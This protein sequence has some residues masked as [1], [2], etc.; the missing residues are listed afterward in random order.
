[1]TVRRRVK[2]LFE[3]ATLNGG[4]HSFLAVAPFLLSEFDVSALL[5]E[6]GPL[7]PR[8]EQ[9][10]IPVTILPGP[11]RAQPSEKRGQ[12]EH[13]LRE[14]PPDLLHANS[15]SMARLAAPVARTLAIPCLGHLRDIAN[16]S[17]KTID[18]LSQA[19]LLL[20]VSAATQ[21]WYRGLGIPS[22]TLA[23][24]HNGVCLREFHPGP[25][26]GPVR[27]ELDLG[28]APVVLGIGQLGLRKGFDVWLTA[29]SMIATEIP[30][31][32]FLIVG[33][34]HSQKQ[35]TVDHVTELRRRSEAGILAGRVRWLGR[36]T[37]TAQLLRESDLV[38]HCARQEPLG[39]V[40]IEAIAVGKPIVATDVG[41]AREILPPESWPS[42]LGEVDNAQDLAEKAVRLLG[43]AE[44]R[45]E[46]SHRHAAFAA[47]HFSA[48]QSARG[49]IEH[50][51]SACSGD[52]GCEEKDR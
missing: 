38:L 19:S 32:R 3:Y 9:L 24:L 52:A 33:E 34:Q 15:L 35:E 29:A 11:R 8:L 27:G 36:R 47:A 40:L 10:A 21:C 50:Y 17:P 44:L 16:L 12:L 42:S 5:L 2:V 37:D 26:L 45:A 20:A 28:E 7:K 31:A 23:V 41:G 49:L 30:D 22:A 6:E 51:R 4:E 48:A 43:S 25:R 14:S 39:R 13:A 1:M 46:M 18:D